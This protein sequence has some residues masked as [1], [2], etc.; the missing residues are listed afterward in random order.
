MFRNPLAMGLE[1]TNP[2][3]SDLSLSDSRS[4]QAERRQRV[5]IVKFI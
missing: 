4:N 1:P 5:S 3:V 2:K